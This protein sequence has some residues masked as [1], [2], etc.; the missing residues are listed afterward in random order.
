MRT[1]LLLAVGLA[2]ASCTTTKPKPPLQA[3]PIGLD[4]PPAG[5]GTT[6]PQMVVARPASMF[7]KLLGRT[8]KPWVVQP[9]TAHRAPD[10][11]N[12]PVPSK[13]KG[14]TF[15]MVTGNQTNAEKK[16]QVLGDGASVKG[17][18]KAKGNAAVSQDSSTQNALTGAGNQSNTKGNNNATTQTKQDT[19]KEA[20]GPL[21]V[22]ANNATSWL[23]WVLGAVAVC[24]VCYGIYY[25]WFLIPRRKASTDTPTV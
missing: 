17:D 22:L 7:D 16:A 10:I 15:N 23:P 8:P 14:C 11:G 18:T 21:A 1:Y 20:L 2:L 9:I 19:S 25:F 6:P 12:G 3:E 24:G 5:L 13:C 4:T